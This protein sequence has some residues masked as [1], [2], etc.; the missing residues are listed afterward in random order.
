MY[1]FSAVEDRENQLAGVEAGDAVRSPGRRIIVRF[2]E[3]E[4]KKRDAYFESSVA[5]VEAQGDVLGTQ[6]LSQEFRRLKA[7]FAEHGDCFE[8]HSRQAEVIGEIRCLVSSLAVCLSRVKIDLAKSH[9]GALSDRAIW[10]GVRRGAGIDM[11]LDQGSLGVL[12]RGVH[13]NALLASRLK[14]PNET[15]IYRALRAR[16]LLPGSYGDKIMG[17]VGDSVAGTKFKTSFFHSEL[18]RSVEH[19]VTVGHVVST[20]RRLRA[21]LERDPGKNFAMKSEASGYK[22][23]MFYELFPSSVT[24]ASDSLPDGAVDARRWGDNFFIHGKPSRVRDVFYFLASHIAE[25]LKLDEIVSSVFPDGNV[26]KHEALRALWNFSI[27]VEKRFSKK[28]ADV[29]SSSPGV[30]SVDVLK[31]VAG[32]EFILRKIRDRDRN[33]DGKIEIVLENRLVAIE[34]W[35]SEM[36]F[37]STPLEKVLWEMFQFKLGDEVA[38]SELAVKTGLSEVEVFRAIENGGKGG[39]NLFEKSKKTVFEVVSCGDAIKISF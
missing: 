16:F 12:L 14:V 6:L 34:K 39:K 27:E 28:L 5:G 35:I 7:E 33:P 29:K 26:D 3:K 1:R 15:E 24:Y 22:S 8:K 32:S 25:P 9:A 37:P 17:A 4:E 20:I 30:R 21:Q 23:T 10:E 36:A 2:G 11:S 18:R 19:E 31:E 38:V 13:R